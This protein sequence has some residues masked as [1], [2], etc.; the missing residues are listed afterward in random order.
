MKSRF[1][2]PYW[3]RFAGYASLLAFIALFLIDEDKFFFHCIVAL[4]VGLMLIAFS[5]EK[6]EDEQIAQLRLDS[7]QWAM[8]LTY[9]MLLILLI[10]DKGKN[11]RPVVHFTLRFQLLF[12]ILRFK[13][14]LFRLNRSLKTG[15]N[16]E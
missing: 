5:K 1:L 2:F 13:W 12:F 9:G 14:V 4:V 7:L 3:G 6:F 10:I 16:P 15:T 8:Y 11:V